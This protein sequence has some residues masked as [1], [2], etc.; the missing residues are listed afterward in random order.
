[1]DEAQKVL[2]MVF[3][4]NNQTTEVLQPGEQSLHFVT[5]AVSPQR[6]SV[7]CCRLFSVA[8]VGR[9][10]FNSGRRQL[11][12]QRVA[13]IR[14]ISDQSLREPACEA[15]EES[16]SDKG[17]FRRRSRRCVNGE[18]KTS[19]VCHCHELRTFAPL[20]FSH[21]EP[22][23]LATTNIPSM[24]HSLRSSSPR[25]RR[26]SASASSTLRKTPSRT[27]CWNRRWQVWYGGKRSGKSSH[28]AP[29]LRP[30]GC[31]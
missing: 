21:S 7:L 29:L 16:V 9:D 10:H 4:S 6:A 27:H 22:P 14:L 8:S 25:A 15:F 13:V 30:R 12:V 2:L 19:A 24:K 1:M 28:R 5:S 26:S 31:H 17:D 18:R 11:F 23:F 3:I 20:G